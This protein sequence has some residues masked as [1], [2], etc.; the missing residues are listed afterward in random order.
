[1]DTDLITQLID[2]DFE[3]YEEEADQ[4]PVP[5]NHVEQLLTALLPS[6]TNSESEEEDEVRIE[7]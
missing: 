2:E 1:M 3:D 6:A 5:A 4:D 7:W